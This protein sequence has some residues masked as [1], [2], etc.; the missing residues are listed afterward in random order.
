[1][2]ITAANFASSQSDTPIQWAEPETMRK[3]DFP[4][5]FEMI[6]DPE[7]RLQKLKV[8]RPSIRSLSRATAPILMAVAV[9]KSVEPQLR[10]SLRL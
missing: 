6:W 1:M 5:V 4:A 3:T 10:F 8:H 2:V 7:V 9:E